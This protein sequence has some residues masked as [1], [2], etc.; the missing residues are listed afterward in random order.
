MNTDEGPRMN[1][2]NHGMRKPMSGKFTLATV[3]SEIAL[4]WLGF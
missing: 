1:M 2:Q 4:F 3:L